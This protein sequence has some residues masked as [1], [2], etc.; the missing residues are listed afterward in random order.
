MF[1][2]VGVEFSLYSADRYHVENL[3]KPNS[4]YQFSVITKNKR[5]WS[6]PSVPSNKIKTDVSSPFGT[7]EDLRVSVL[8]PG[9]FIVEWKVNLL[10]EASAF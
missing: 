8:R 1:D 6:R 2:F 3:L 4:F 5:G 9:Q 10:I 7:V